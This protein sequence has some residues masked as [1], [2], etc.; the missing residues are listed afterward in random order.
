MQP[1]PFDKTA[2][3]PTQRRFPENQATS[4]EN[5][6]VVRHQEADP[7]WLDNRRLA[8]ENAKLREAIVE[9]VQAS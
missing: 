1:F 6:E 7:L 8:D 9:Y 2:T 5:S 4:P 3:G